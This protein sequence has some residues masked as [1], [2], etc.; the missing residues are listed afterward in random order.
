MIFLK[1]VRTLQ[2]EHIKIREGYVTASAGAVL[3]RPNVALS[4]AY[5]DADINLYKAKNEGRN[6]F[7]ISA[8]ELAA[9]NL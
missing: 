7:V 4:T 6:R 3:V 2:L 9:R 5:H 1:A 8:H